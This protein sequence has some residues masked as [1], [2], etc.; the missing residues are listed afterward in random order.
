MDHHKVLPPWSFCFSHSFSIK[1]ITRH[2]YSIPTIATYLTK[3]AEDL[4]N[5]PTIEKDFVSEIFHTKNFLSHPLMTQINPDKT[6]VI[7]NK[8][9][10]LLWLLYYDDVE[11]NRCALKNHNQF[12]FLL[13]ES[14]KELSRMSR[15]SE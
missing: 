15:F 7:I 3:W 14:I 1:K 2:Y 4:T 12:I 11:L 5:N 8:G 13:G 9:M 6:F 10:N